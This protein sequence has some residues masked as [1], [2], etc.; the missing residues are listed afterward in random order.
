[1]ALGK[2][3]VCLEDF[4]KEAERKLDLNAWGYYQSG[5]MKEE[6]LRDNVEAYS[7]YLE[8]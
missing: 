5:A 8:L 7:R 1:M 3:F 2:T 6:T 4:E